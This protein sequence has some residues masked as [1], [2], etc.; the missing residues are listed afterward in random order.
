MWS[1]VDM[2]IVKILFMVE[3]GV[4]L[5]YYISIETKKTNKE[6]R[7]KEKWEKVT[8]VYAKH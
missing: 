1:L 7:G 5:W 4:Y 3:L 6:N 2:E 8:N